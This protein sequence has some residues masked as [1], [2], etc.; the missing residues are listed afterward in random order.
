MLKQPLI[1][2]LF[3]LTIFVTTA[4]SASATP[5]VPE[6]DPP[7]SA[8]ADTGPFSAV[9]PN[10][11]WNEQ[12]SATGHR[13]ISHVPSNPKAMTFFLH[14]GGGGAII[15]QRTDITRTINNLVDK[16]FGF[17]S[18]DSL[19]RVNKRWDIEPVTGNPD[20]AR[21]MAF[22][23]ELIIQG[24][25]TSSTPIYFWAYSNGGQ[26]SYSFSKL[27]VE[28][29]VPLRAIA[30]H[31]AS[32]AIVLPDPVPL[33][34][35]PTFFSVLEN[36]IDVDGMTIFH[37]PDNIKGI[38]D[39]ITANGIDA[40]YHVGLEKALN[41]LRF[42]Q[43]PGVT[44]DLAQEVFDILVSEGVID[45]NGL[46][47]LDLSLLDGYAP[48][49]SGLISPLG[50]GFG[51]N[52]FQDEV[53]RQLDVVWARHVFSGEF[54]DERIRFFESH[55]PVPE[56]STLVAMLTGGVILFGWRRVKKKRE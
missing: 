46:R 18:L 50:P 42:T 10:A 34:S 2:T 39:G 28:S 51:F 3:T 37:K 32:P 15:V 19:D 48:D 17:A 55:Q 24:K 38:F 56:P 31:A 40:E 49:L 52:F 29:G 23:N 11:V 1:Q 12:V 14:G 20:F 6:F 45:T 47:L 9:T 25:I 21:L 33:I 27:A 22:R 8:E 43:I 7:V 16:G 35:V 4:V 30:T 5:L 36:D 13:V 44:P 53:G 54:D 41:P 26:A